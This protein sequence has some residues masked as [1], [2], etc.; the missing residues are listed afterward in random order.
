MA[1]YSLV[2]ALALLVLMSAQQQASADS[3]GVGQG[4]TGLVSEPPFTGRAQRNMD[5]VAAASD[6]VTAAAAPQNPPYLFY[7][8]CV[9]NRSVGPAWVTLSFNSTLRDNQ[10]LVGASCAIRSLSVSSCACIASDCGTGP[11]KNGT[12]CCNQDTTAINNNWWAMDVN[13]EDS[14]SKGNPMWRCRWQKMKGNA[15]TAGVSEMFVSYYVAT[16]SYF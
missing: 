16:L 15:N 1:S 10:V 5:V 14:D 6:V 12:P 3:A 9:P 11:G 4:G 8:F 2:K 7:R 13:T